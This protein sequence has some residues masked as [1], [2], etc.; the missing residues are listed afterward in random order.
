VIIIEQGEVE[1]LPKLEYFRRFGMITELDRI[2][3][4]FEHITFCQAQPVLVEGIYR[5]IKNPIRAISRAMYCDGKF[6]HCLDRYLTGLGICELAVYAGVPIMQAWALRLI[7]DGGLK[8]PLGSVDKLPALSVNK[9]EISIGSIEMSTRRSFESA[10]GFDVSEQ[11][12]FESSFAGHL[13]SSPEIQA[14]IH[15]YRNFHKN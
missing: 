3:E 7:S 8:R 1:K 6:S 12:K 9:G 10:F 2:A 4:T 11:L 14:Y 15:K 13:E 5:F